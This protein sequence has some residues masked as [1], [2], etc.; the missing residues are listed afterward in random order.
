MQSV[1][2]EELAQYQIPTKEELDRSYEVVSVVQ[3]SLDQSFSGNDSLVI[4]S[5]NE[6]QE[7]RLQN[8]TPLAESYYDNENLKPES[9][10]FNSQVPPAPA[11]PAIHDKLFSS[12]IEDLKISTD[13]FKQQ[14]EPSQPTS[15][16]FVTCEKIERKMSQS[17]EFDMARSYD[18]DVALS[19]SEQLES[20]VIDD[21]FTSNLTDRSPKE[22]VSLLDAGDKLNKTLYESLDCVQAVDDF[23]GALASLTMQ[24]VYMSQ[25]DQ[26]PEVRS[27]E[28]SPETAKQS[29]YVSR[30]DESQDADIENQGIPNLMEISVSKL[31]LLDSEDCKKQPSSFKESVFEEFEFHDCEDPEVQVNPLI[32]P[33]SDFSAIQDL[34]ESGLEEPYQ[35]KSFNFSCFTKP[36]CLPASCEI[37]KPLTLLRRPESTLLKVKAKTKYLSQYVKSTHNLCD[38]TQTYSNVYLK[39]NIQILQVDR[40]DLRA[41]ELP[42]AV[43]LLCSSQLQAPTRPLPDLQT[44]TKSDSQ[45]AERPVY[46][47]L[48]VTA[49]SMDFAYKQLPI[50]AKRGLT[51]C[52]ALRR[53]NIGPEVRKEAIPDSCIFLSLK[54]RPMTSLQQSKRNSSQIQ[55][56]MRPLFQITSSSVIS[57]TPIDRTYLPVAQ[58][59]KQTFVLFSKPCTYLERTKVT[60][61]QPYTKQPYILETWEKTATIQHLIKP[62]SKPMILT[63]YLATNANQVAVEEWASLQIQPVE[64]LMIPLL[65]SS[66]ICVIERPVSLQMISAE[67][68][69]SRHR[70][71]RRKNIGL[72][73]H[74][75]IIPDSVTSYTPLR[76]PE[77]LLHAAANVPTQMLSVLRKPMVCITNSNKVRFDSVVKPL[78]HS[79]K[80]VDLEL[81]PLRKPYTHSN[82][83]TTEKFR[84]LTRA[85]QRSEEWTKSNIQIEA[86]RME[87]LLEVSVLEAWYKPV[88]MHIASAERSISQHRALQ[89][90]LIELEYRFTPFLTIS[91]PSDSP[92]PKPRP[93]D[94]LLSPVLLSSPFD[95]DTPPYSFSEPDKALT[96]PRF[97]QDSL[98]T[99]PQMFSPFSIVK[100]PK[101][102]N[103]W[104]LGLRSYI[105][106]TVETQFSPR[107]LYVVERRFNDL[108]W[109]YKDITQNFKGYNV[110][111]LP[112]KQY[113]GN[114]SEE[115]VEE[116]RLWIEKFLN[117]LH[118]HPNI[119]SSDQLRQ[120]LTLPRTELKDLKA[121]SSGFKWPKF[122]GFEN[123]FDK[124][125]VEAYSQLSDYLTQGFNPLSNEVARTESIAE[126]YVI[127]T[128]IC[129][130]AFGQLVQ[131]HAE[132]NEAIKKLNL[133][134]SERFDSILNSYAS[135]T[136]SRQQ[137]LVNYLQ[138]FREERLRVEGLRNAVYQYTAELQYI[139]KKENLL[140]TK[141]ARQQANA[142]A[143][144]LYEN[145]IETI[146]EKIRQSKDELN[147]IE[148][149]L[150]IEGDLYIQKRAEHLSRMISNVTSFMLRKSQNEARFWSDVSPS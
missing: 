143:A 93:E 113:F 46:N 115:F 8:S 7:F 19:K 59:S 101:L 136:E 105:L 80:V 54:S 147:K 28:C 145:E 55:I 82:E 10:S 128:Q 75:E 41:F 111:P 53:Q 97:S 149:A 65:E 87:I 138:D 86:K 36:S 20:M 118:K 122:E 88:A 150:K 63:G 127:P 45:L 11:V 114:T 21:L 134:R 96:T 67:R 71:S 52:K 15:Q 58:I 61:L 56:M 110:P 6:D 43:G 84:S 94:G 129:V 4:Q 50:T 34:D 78:T 137:E 72:E 132:T 42:S 148:H 109:F 24:S 139:K 73:F 16:P 30:L 76:R 102:M 47:P 140:S 35:G 106:Y 83:C 60:T 18:D 141:L 120:F 99:T 64:R 108:E 131:T 31:D 125:K 119:G 81:K 25:L 95:L 112:K 17:V 9:L 44:W 57:L 135:F 124:V 70:A 126:T 77:V 142:A 39:P 23:V 51:I 107:E 104:G 33:P 98:Y 32:N 49:I 12:S 40:R 85:V 79:V 133:D 14:E 89:K 123:T 146:K 22:E 117:L 144:T 66:K 100:D 116:R 3:R 29:L 90:T 27:V 26:E 68:F 69:L 5:L 37:I 62:A 91:L 121:Q 1:T 130:E 13:Y 103:T 74:K 38:I 92:P 2:E 48:V